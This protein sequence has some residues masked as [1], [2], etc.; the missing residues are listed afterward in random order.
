M[1]YPLVTFPWK[2]RQ[3]VRDVF[4]ELYSNDMKHQN[5]A[6]D[7]I[8]AWESRALSRIPLAVETTAA[9]VKA[10]IQYETA[11]KPVGNSIRLR[12]QYSMAIIRFV[13][14]FTERS[15]QKAY[16]LPVHV[17]A[18]RMG[19]P[20]WI[21][22]L[23][24]EATHD[25]LPSLTELRAAADWCLQW[26]KT[27]FWEVQG[28]DQNSTYE[29]KFNN[30]QMVKDQLV[31]Y[32]QRQFEGIAMDGS[33]P[34]KTFLEKLESLFSDVGEE[35][36]PVIVDD[37]YLVFTEE[38]LSSIGL[39]KDELL[40]ED[41]TELPTE[42]KKFWKPAIHLLAKCK[43]LPSLLFHVVMSLTHL[44]TLRN[45]F[46]SKW[47]FHLIDI[48]SFNEKNPNEQSMQWAVPYNTLL[49][50]CLKSDC[51]SSV[52]R[53][54]FDLLIS[55]SNL[56]LEQ[57]KKLRHIKLLLASEETVENT[58][59]HMYTVEDIKKPGN[60]TV[61]PWKRCA[62]SIEWSRLP[63]GVLPD[64]STAYSSLELGE[65][66]PDLQT[67]D[68]AVPAVMEQDKEEEVD[69]RVLNYESV[70]CYTI[71]TWDQDCIKSLAD[72]MFI[73]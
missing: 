15:Q 54:S 25:S 12:E 63:F 29:E 33:G 1:A 28:Q 36:C 27:E 22:D 55:K 45:S 48:N 73:F 68:I 24:H 53:R 64:Q 51:D 30:I 58:N 71:A 61:N 72:N 11:E 38:Q 35:I 43:L 2:D 57:K 40:K 50:R 5:H 42:L 39:S 26:L 10:N 65:V 49:D 70:Q 60:E 31:I 8:R 7:R 17:L 16:A 41:D 13:N 32:M 21:V 66:L 9:M 69:E 18:S 6:V 4:A 52:M 47:F 3:E 34:S 56:K 23:R 44:N 20:A 19:V 46:L 67:E 62:N 37:G 59:E 14:L